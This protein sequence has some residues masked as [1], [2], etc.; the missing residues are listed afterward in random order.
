M[1]LVAE[2]KNTNTDKLR[3]LFN[4]FFPTNKRKVHFSRKIL[5]KSF[6]NESYLFFLIENKF[7]TYKTKFLLSSILESLTY[8]ILGI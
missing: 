7:I 4:F 6:Y 8:C 1:I 3:A 2:F 5:W